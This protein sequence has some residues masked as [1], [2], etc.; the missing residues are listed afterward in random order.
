MYHFQLGIAT[1]ANWVQSLTE[2]GELSK[3]SEK[4]RDEYF[5]FNG[6]PYLSKSLCGYDSPHDFEESRKHALDRFD[7][8][9]RIARQRRE[10]F[11]IILSLEE[12]QK[13][14][15]KN[16]II[17]AILSLAP[18][19]HEA[20]WDFVDHPKNKDG[21]PLEHQ[22]R[23][24]LALEKLGVMPTEG[25]MFNDFELFAE[26]QINQE[27]LARQKEWT[28]SLRHKINKKAKDFEEYLSPS[29]TPVVSSE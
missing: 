21:R 11:L 19:E 17:R 4:E 22:L 9:E 14:F 8:I 26:K 10:S 2:K 20:F 5:A 18:H 29:R 25:P 1:L 28:P 12:I 16:D 27:I 15:L 3:L 23:I 13:A 7:R 6:A 24:Q